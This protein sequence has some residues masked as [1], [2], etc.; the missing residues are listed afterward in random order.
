MAVGLINR[1]YARYRGREVRRGGDHGGI[2]TLRRSRR[3][4][5]SAG[6]KSLIWKSPV[7]TIAG[8]SDSVLMTVSFPILKL[9]L[10]LARSL[11]RSLKRL[12]CRYGLTTLPS[13]IMR[14]W[15]LKARSPF[16]TGGVYRTCRLLI[17]AYLLIDSSR[18]RRLL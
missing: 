10:K 7:C 15:I 14:G 3:T 12:P 13:K 1:G 11:H 8:R 5:G 18:E 9:C 2:R 6:K 16:Y 17:L 4:S